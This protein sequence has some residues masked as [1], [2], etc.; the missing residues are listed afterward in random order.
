MKFLFNFSL[1]LISILAL[2]SECF[3]LPIDSFKSAQSITGTSQSLVNIS[4]IKSNDSLGGSR[5][6]NARLVSGNLI[7]ADTGLNK[8]GNLNIGT[9]ENSRGIFSVLW[10][11]IPSIPRYSRK[12]KFISLYIDNFDFNLENPAELEIELQN[13]NKSEFH[14]KVVLNRSYKNEILDIPLSNFKIYGLSQLI[15]KITLNSGQID[16]ASIRFSEQPSKSSSLINRAAK[17][18]QKYFKV[19]AVDKKTKGQIKGAKITFVSFSGTSKVKTN[20]NGEALK[21][22]EQGAKVAIAF[23]HKSYGSTTTNAF[24]LKKDKTLRLKRKW[25]GKGKQAK[26]V[27]VNNERTPFPTPINTFPPGFT[28]PPGF[29]PT[30]DFTFPPNLS[31]TPN[32]TTT[33]NIFYTLTPT[34]NPQFSPTKTPLISRTPLI[35]NTPTNIPTL[36]STRTPTI[37]FSPTRTATRTSTITPSITPTHTSTSTPTTPPLW[38]A[39]LPTSTAASVGQ[40]VS[41]FCS[42][43]GG[44]GGQYS[45]RWVNEFGAQLSTLQTYIFTVTKAIHNSRYKCIVSRGSETVETNFQTINVFHPPEITSYN[46]PSILNTKEDA[47]VYF[48]VS[49]TGYPP[50]QIE[51]QRDNTRISLSNKT[52]IVKATDNNIAFRVVASNSLGFVTSPT[53]TFK[54]VTRPVFLIHPSNRSLYAGSTASFSCTAKSTAAISYQW[55]YTVSGSNTFVNIPGANGTTYSVNATL[56]MNQNRYRCVVSNSEFTNITSYPATLTVVAVPK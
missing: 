26:L 47:S 34:V 13:D 21:Y 35:S 4:S 43:S 55:Q 1:Y 9:S 23:S 41:V 18:D 49:A 19:I 2:S 37:Y 48:Q 29:T 56:Q 10:D 15:L 50:A 31:P 25:N 52:Y 24:S 51:W 44:Q 20:K 7:Y 11:K 6:I 38:V 3:S 36:T 22:F 12:A 45:Y 32:Y 30:P 17:S 54:V 46:L 42:P 5:S 14:N 33:P 39:S 8:E 53:S 27:T 16:I 28:L 40:S